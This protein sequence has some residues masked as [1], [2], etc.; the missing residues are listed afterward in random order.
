MESHSCPCW[1]KQNSRLGAAQSQELSFQSR[2]FYIKFFHSCRGNGTWPPHTSVT[3]GPHSS[4]AAQC[5]P[6]LHC[7][8][9][10]IRGFRC[11][12]PTC[13]PASQ[14]LQPRSERLQSYSASFS[15]HTGW[16]QHCQR[17]TSNYVWDFNIQ[18]LL[19]K[20][21]ILQ[22]IQIYISLSLIHQPQLY[23]LTQCTTSNCSCCCSVLRQARLN[24]SIVSM[25]VNLK[26]KKSLNRPTYVC[27]SFGKVAEMQ[28][29]LPPSPSPPRKLMLPSQHKAEETESTNTSLVWQFCTLLRVSINLHGFSEGKR[30]LPTQLWDLSWGN[31]AVHLSSH[32]T[33]WLR[34]AKYSEILNFGASEHLTLQ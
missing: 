34:N 7:S 32:S 19:Q 18:E 29:S 22:N 21:C 31:P 11:A 24:Q 23:L 28:Y 6:A 27:K 10:H 30:E 9:T 15:T 33:S 25:K 8:T 12:T 26:K 3:P 16:F 1:T 4:T 17:K 13:Y 2:W 14:Q 20:Q 5:F